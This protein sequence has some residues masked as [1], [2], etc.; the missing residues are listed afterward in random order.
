ML[1]SDPHHLTDE[2]PPKPGQ[3]HREDKG[4]A[5]SYNR[6]TAVDEREPGAVVATKSTQKLSTCPLKFGR[7]LILITSDV[8]PITPDDQTEEPQKE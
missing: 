4:N 8:S 5:T 2:G 3:D 1:F 6:D 7:I